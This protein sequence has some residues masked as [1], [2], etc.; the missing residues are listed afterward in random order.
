MEQMVKGL[1]R[2]VPMI[3]PGQIDF[4]EKKE[5]DLKK[6]PIESEPMEFDDLEEI[7]EH[8]IGD[9]DVRQA[10]YSAR[11]PSYLG[12]HDQHSDSVKEHIAISPEV[13][14]DPSTELAKSRHQKAD[15]V[16]D[17]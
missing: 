11:K 8:P 12:V 9:L 2:D 15:E 7:E 3:D 6:V 14:K 4:G 1:E 17:E 5:N 13:I 16:G 10:P